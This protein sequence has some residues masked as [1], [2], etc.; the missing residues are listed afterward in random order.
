MRR[1]LACRGFLEPLSGF[2]P[3]FLQPRAF[4]LTLHPQHIDVFEEATTSATPTATTCRMAE[5]L[6]SG[7]GPDGAGGQVAANSLNALLKKSKKPAVRP[8]LRSLLTYR[9]DFWPPK[10][11]GSAMLPS[12]LTPSAAAFIACCAAWWTRARGPRPRP[13]P[14]PP[15]AGL[16]PWYHLYCC[17]C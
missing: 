11:P 17:S 12:L 7:Q 9:L 15:P 14:H 16:F 1:P 4:S 2:R 8:C 5:M 10:S 13:H 6:Q 3:G